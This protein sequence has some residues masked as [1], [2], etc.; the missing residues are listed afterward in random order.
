MKRRVPAGWW[1]RRESNSR[2]KQRPAR[3]L[4]AYSRFCNLTCPAP[5]GADPDKP[6]A[7]LSP[8]DGRDARRERVSG[9]Y[10]GRRS[11]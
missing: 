10:A 7:A 1:R 2:P 4:R 9:V 8:P 5:V 11:C 6:V 3:H